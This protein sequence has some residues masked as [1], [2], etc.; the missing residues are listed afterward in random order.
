MVKVHEFYKKYSLRTL[1]IPVGEKAPIH[2]KRWQDSTKPI[3]EVQE[4]LDSQPDRFNKYGWLLDEDHVVIDIDV[5]DPKENG[6]DA[7]A[8]LESKLGFTLE[9]KC[10]AIVRTPSGGA[11]FYF[12]KEPSVKFGKVFKQHYAGIDFIG[13]KGKQ[14][15]AANSLH[16]KCSGFYSMQG[17]KLFPLPQEVIDH[18][19]SLRDVDA[20][21]PVSVPSQ[22][23]AGDEFNKSERGLQLLIAELQSSGY[24]VRRKQ[25]YY[26][27]DRPGK[28][29]DSTYSGH[30]GKL[31]QQGNYQLTCFS[32]SDANFPSGESMSIFH[33]YALL[34]C[35]G[36]HQRAAQALYE[37]NFAVVD[38]GVDLSEFNFGNK[39]TEDTVESSDGEVDLSEFSIPVRSIEDAMPHVKAKQAKSDFPEDC[40]RPEGILTEIIDYNLARSMYPKPDLALAGALAL[41][42]T[43]TGRKVQN[44]YG[45]RTNCYILGI[46]PSGS[47]K[48]Q[49][50]KVN[51]DLMTLAGAASMLGPERIGSSAGLVT[52]MTVSPSCL[53]QIDEIGKLLATI[54]QGGAKSP[55][56]FNIVSV[57]MQLYSSADC[58]WVGDA[59]A[60]QRKTPRINQ[61]HCVV[62]GTAVPEGFW[63][64]LTKENVTD[65]L[66]GRAM[67]FDS[68]GYVKSKQPSLIDPPQSLIDKLAW[69][70][71]FNPGGNLSG[72]NPQPI[73]ARHTPNGLERFRRH[74][75]EIDD[76]KQDD[77]PE[78]AAIWSRSGERAA[79]LALLLAVSRQPMTTEIEIYDSDVNWGIKVSNWMTRK[80]L[81]AAMRHISENEVEAQRKKI[82]QLI[83]DN[84]GEITA[85]DLSR[86]LHMKARDREMAVTDLLLS[87]VIF[88]DTK[89]TSQR[90]GSHSVVYRVCARP[91]GG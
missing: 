20:G 29:T 69:W 89:P 46:A 13:G 87:Q 26:E 12:S 54:K 10:G 78:A 4:A 1:E 83:I 66:L 80:L 22:E 6:W 47:G 53:L 58:M 51:K 30:V 76:R 52:A 35:R 43:I 77:S 86:R 38:Y 59:Y 23:R 28:T 16:D 55:H 34:T 9:S 39:P 50:R 68:P 75:S 73:I 25:G 82:V 45:T 3:D 36:D 70:V 63:D 14:V 88:R 49:A 79:K 91:F 37:R 24:T 27:F 21:I 7:L 64:G 41:L 81:S 31:S 5:H 15:V 57:L 40:L 18:L 60:D 33:A 90:N 42:A 84:G 67:I 56:L 2:V 8:R 17:G 65:G 44:D 62:Y 32:L 19:L 71:K 74:Q 11:H 61:P 85:R 48:D 72:E